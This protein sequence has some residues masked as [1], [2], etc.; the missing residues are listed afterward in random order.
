[1]PNPFVRL[2][3]PALLAI[4]SGALSAQ[5]PRPI[6]VSDLA[7]LRSVGA[8][9]ISPDAK[10]V[11]YSISTPD[12][13]KD[14][15]SSRIW[16]SLVSGG[17]A[18][19]MTGAG[20][21]GSNPKWSPDGKYLGF[22]A[23]RNGGESQVWTLNRMGGE[24]EQLTQVKQGVEDFEWSPDGAR[25]LLTLKDP[26][27][28]RP[29]GDSANPQPPEPVVVDR[30]QF[31][32]DVAGYLDR[33][34]T[35]LYGFEIA[36]KKLTQLTS[37]DF[38]D[39]DP[40]WSP[41]GKLVAF[42]SN[43]TEEPD[44]NRNSDIWIVAAD[45]TDKGQT[46][47]R[48]TTNPGSDDS[49]AWSP[50]GRTI[51]YVT[52]TDVPA[53]WYATQ[54]LAVIPA[55]GG[56]PA[57]PTRSMDRNVSSP[58]YSPDGKEIYFLLEDSG[59]S[60]LMKIPAAGGAATPVIGG[61]R[62]V[63]PYDMAPDGR[64]VARIAE[65]TFPGELFTL[66]GAG[67]GAPA[68]L[69]HV[70]DSLLATLRLAQV[71]NIHFKSRDGTGI[72]GF[73]YYPLGYD[74]SLRYP[75]LLRIHGGPVSQFEAAFSFEAQLFAANGYAVVNVNPRGSSGYGQAFSQAIFADWG[76]KDFEDVMAGVDYAIATGVA[77]STRLGVGGWSYGGILTN[78]VIT[79]STRFKGAISGASEALI[80]GNY[81]HDH[82]QLEYEQELGLPWRNRAAYEK[83]SSFN[84]VEKIV[85]PTL[86]IGGAE[87]WNV[88]I[89]NSEQMYQ[90]MR[91]MGR[92]TQ[93]VV[94]P[95]EHHG[96]T[97]LSFQRDRLE[98]YLGWYG[99]YVKGAVP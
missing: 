27:P 82:Y 84:D 4:P 56:T 18:I 61:F 41:D 66:A 48:V 98:R 81:G 9:R 85:T 70:N 58:R 57:L 64:I 72:E 6:A 69:T 38:D 94:Y 93:L 35:H 92:Q 55:A 19:P 8:P 97:R 15:S 17:P 74:R 37:G 20:L 34:R 59:E 86:W 88:P 89:L 62:S 52:V 75:T 42:T 16:M 36:G 63:G 73:L 95:G 31:K 25:L 99:K 5:T 3:L 26:R 50:D 30:L 54:H 87:D 45:N 32:R 90:A 83:L 71:E 10:Q 65:P 22:T 1:M 23:A 60:H 24:A 28:D 96:I 13:A 80:V 53:M 14:R 77:D 78:Y 49:P 68:R 21:P 39:S 11:A 44:N 46:L 79:K 12:P 7:A 40:A 67:A 33:R 29:K 2:V 51:T 76:N 91:R 43:R 47:R